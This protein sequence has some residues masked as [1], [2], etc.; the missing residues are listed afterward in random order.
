MALQFLWNDYN[1]FFEKKR[2]P[3]ELNG[4]GCFGSSIVRILAGS[5]YSLFWAQA[6][7]AIASEETKCG[8]KESDMLMRKDMVAWMNRFDFIL[9][10]YG[11]C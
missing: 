4:P 5:G 6:A 9:L 1:C 8:C 2:F 11:K 7:Y 3:E 10:V